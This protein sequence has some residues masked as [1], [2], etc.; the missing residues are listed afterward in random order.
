MLLN[1]AFALRRYRLPA[2]G[3][4]MVYIQNKNPTLGKFWRA[5]DWKMLIYFMAIST[6]LRTL[7]IF[8]DHLVHF[9]FIWYNFSGFDIVYQEKSGNP[10]MRPYILCEKSRKM[11]PD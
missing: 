10:V 11:W 8:Y 5:L 3:C 4:Q 7:G 2:Q 6:I 1:E 9:V